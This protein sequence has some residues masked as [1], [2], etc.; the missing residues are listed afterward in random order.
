MFNLLIN[1]CRFPST[2]EPSS[3]KLFSD[4]SLDQ[5]LVEKFEQDTKTEAE[6][7]FKQ[8]QSNP[9]AVY[10]PH[11]VVDEDDPLPEID[12]EIE[13]AFK[14]CESQLSY[15][16]TVFKEYQFLLSKPHV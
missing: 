13:T 11:E 5:G 6:E 12:D 4:F 2:D 8:S 7:I 1:S 14:S 3:F 10:E 15:L 16:R 9:Y